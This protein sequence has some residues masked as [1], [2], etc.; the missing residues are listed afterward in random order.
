VNVYS[1][2]SDSTHRGHFEQDSF[3]AIDCTHTDNCN[4]RPT[5]KRYIPNTQKLLW[6]NDFR[7]E[8]HA[9]TQKVNS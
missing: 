1:L 5:A 6:Y 3:K 9:Q 4:Q 7:A 2:A 8:K